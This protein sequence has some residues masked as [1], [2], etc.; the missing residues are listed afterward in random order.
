V[1][2]QKILNWE[3][4]GEYWEDEI[5]SYRSTLKTIARRVCVVMPNLNGAAHSTTAKNEYLFLFK[6]IY[7]KFNSK[8]SSDRLD[9]ERWLFVSAKTILKN[10]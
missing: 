5:G 1:K 10:N 6:G 2:P 8:S 7:E 9:R 4:D 3:F